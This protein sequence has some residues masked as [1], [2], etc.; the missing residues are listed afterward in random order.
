ALHT[1]HFSIGSGTRLAFEDAIA[2][3]RAFTQAGEDVPAALA[4]FE[5][6]RRPV[7]EKLLLAAG[8]SSF[9][10]EDFPSRLALAPLELAYDY[11]MRS[12]RMSDER[13]RETA[14]RF[15]QSVQRA[16]ARRA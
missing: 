11:M 7:V 5:R 16:R 1:V 4:A 9:W 14:P 10:Y 8:L 13:L 15:M 2:L 6:D 12:G 3:V